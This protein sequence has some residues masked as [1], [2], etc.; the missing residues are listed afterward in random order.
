M[1]FKVNTSNSQI[2]TSNY[3]VVRSIF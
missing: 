3:R 2:D 1:N